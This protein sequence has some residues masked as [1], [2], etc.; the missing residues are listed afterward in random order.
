M[1]K[2]YSSSIETLSLAFRQRVAEA[3]INFLAKSFDAL[4]AQM[5]TV[6]PVRP[7]IE[8]ISFID[9]INTALI[10]SHESCLFD[11]EA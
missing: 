4:L 6:L 3:L 7:I 1:Q 2:V 10:V 8:R 5:P 9:M 11:V